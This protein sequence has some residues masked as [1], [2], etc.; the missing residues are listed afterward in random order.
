MRNISIPT[1]GNFP[2]RNENGD[3]ITTDGE[4]ANLFADHLSKVFR[5]NPSSN[6]F[7]LSDLVCSEESSIISLD[8]TTNEVVTIIRET[9]NPKKAPG[10]DLISQRMISELPLIAV[11]FL[12]ILFNNMIKFSYFPQAWKIALNENDIE[13]GKG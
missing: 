9:A 12:V 10:Y 6:N 3:W 2:L 8:I 7:N 5:P 1:E 11:K 13:T 4:K